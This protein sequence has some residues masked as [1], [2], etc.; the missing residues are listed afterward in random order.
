MNESMLNSLMKLFAIMVSIN[1]EVVHVLARDFVETFLV[2]EFSQKLAHK[3]LAIFD[4]YT[5]DLDKGEK[6]R[7]SKKLSSLSVKI[8]GICT[9]VV[10]EL[11]IR[12][13]FMILLSLIRFS[14]YFADASTAYSGESGAI[15][16][17][18]R[19]VAD[20]LLIT[21]E[22][23][24]NCKSFIIDKF[25]NVPNRERLLIVSDDTEF[26]DE[27]M[28]H[29]QKDHLSGQIFVLRIMRADT[30][31]FKYVGKARLENNGRYI[32]PRHVYLMP[33][34]S[35]IKGEGITP[36]YYS[37]IV[38]GYIRYTDGHSIDFLARDIQFHFRNSTNGIQQFSFHGRS[39]QLVGII[40][41]SGAGKSTLLKVL[42]GS[43]KL[44]R[45]DIYINGHHLMEESDELEG[46]IGY[47]PQDDLLMEELTVYQNLYFNARLCL[48][49]FTTQEIDE[50]V[51]NLLNDLGLSETRDLK[52]GSPLNKYISGGQRKR[53]NIALELIREPQILF[54][55]EPTSGLSSVD[56]E[57]V[58]A[59]LKE[60]AL[61]GKLVLA[62]IHQPSSDLFRQFDH[63]LVLDRGGYPVYSGNPIEGISYFKR[64]AGRVDAEESECVTCGNT[65]PDDILQVIEAR[66]VDEYGEFTSQR[67]TSPEEW[68]NYYKDNIESG[69]EFSSEK[70]WIPYN[71]FMI[72][73]SLRQFFIYFKRNLLSKL[74]DRQ[75]MSIAL[76][77]SPL[78]AVILGFFS[79]YVSG[80]E[81]DVHAYVFSQNEN[82]PAYLF[83]SVIVAL[84]LGMIIA[85]EEII[86]DRKILE[87][88]SFLNL[89]RTSF[90]F[91]KI[92]L[93]FIFSA[94][95]MLLFVVIGNL[96]M[97]VRGMT[98]SY[99][100]ILFS[101]ACFANLL[102]LNI[103]DGLKS[104]VAIYVIVP[105][106]L[107]PQILLA[108]VIV[109]FDKL[110]YKF[111]SH[112]SVPVAGD[113]MASR[114]A[115][116]ALAVNQFVSNRYQ[117]GYYDMEMLESS[118]TYDLQFLAPTLIQEIRDAQDLFHENQD[119]P[120]L[121]GRLR[122]IQNGFSSIFLTGQ[123]P[124]ISD[125]Q[126]E[127]FNDQVVEKGI[128]WLQDYQSKLTVH[129]ERLT[130]EKDAYTDSLR[131]SLGGTGAYVQFK[132]DY[133]NDQLA[134][135]V[136]NRNDLRRIVEREEQLIRKME[137]VYM[138][139]KSRNGRAHFYA[140]LKT[141]GNLHISTF[142]FN[143]IAIWLMTIV[144][145]FLLRYSV[146]QK[147]LDFFGEQRRKS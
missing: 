145:Y 22:E 138:Y 118:V 1:R 122:T 42:N 68:Y 52:V 105:F 15:S 35:S 129:R 90:L 131:N 130:R 56:S 100:L 144:L 46:M 120:D 13:R 23:Y 18:V 104:V 17:A 57:N 24:E 70:S 123:Y 26:E 85:A 8:L 141:V 72:P 119:H 106:L 111:A 64:L 62:N 10:E 50:T 49:G 82:L 79:K 39:G 96:I 63:L 41:G 47:I 65:N 19:T 133:Y 67:R 80:D 94:I 30:Y 77:V 37:D 84:F 112:Q 86:K 116:E 93:M 110:H 29:L 44:N 134:K 83:M 27:E 31:L 107:V 5:R 121:P 45:G 58:V 140:S 128:A 34:G 71:K 43:L 20:G 21:D 97:E 75:F 48:D 113:L 32:F 132:R 109:K 103:S 137:P 38:S 99:W 6:G 12:Q 76:L 14:K 88:E 115:Y 125:F 91:S 98:F 69:K 95:Q 4:N 11:H 59:L 87:R 60:Q 36:I 66:D 117:E 51:V 146:L 61:S 74:A 7:Q 40:G 3:Y 9:Q 89:N 55:D 142:V 101:T 2:Q 139:P 126:E 54:V 28:R 53:L 25:Y 147:I 33:R 81:N 114:W 16:D 108:G 127:G 124:G 73:G 143:V 136:L 102:G 135:L 78:L 92:G